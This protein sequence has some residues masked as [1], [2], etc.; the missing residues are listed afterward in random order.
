MQYI[1]EEVTERGLLLMRLVEIVRRLECYAVATGVLQEI[2]KFGKTSNWTYAR[3][4]QQTA[5]Q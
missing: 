5:Y 3:G 1:R 2:Y 4:L